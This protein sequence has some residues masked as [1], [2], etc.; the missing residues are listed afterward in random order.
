[1]A[2][3]IL[4]EVALNPARKRWTRAEA[5]RL[6]E[7]FPDQRYELIG[8]EL[9]SKMGQNPL[10]ALVIAIL[11]TALAKAF[12]E[13][14]R[15]QLPIRLPSPDSE[16]TEP[17]PDV[18]VLNKDIREFADHHPGPEDIALLIEVA[19]TSLELDRNIKSGFYARAGIAEYWIMD[20][21]NRRTFVCLQPSGGEYTLIRI[22][23]EHETLLASSV[24]SLSLTLGNLL[25]PCPDR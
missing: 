20:I 11:T 15:I 19:D 9:I 8:G 7:L 3:A 2:I 13:R 12:P 25:P 14:V 18:I 24:P 22:L 10:H 21:V 16:Y 1:V 6:A 23:A 5:D 4:P 17:E